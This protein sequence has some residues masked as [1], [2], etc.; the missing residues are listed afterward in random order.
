MRKQP[1]KNLLKM[2]KRPEQSPHQRK[3]IDGKW[4]YEKMLCV[5]VIRKYK[6]KQKMRYHSMPIRGLKYRTQTVPNA[7]IRIWSFRNSHSMLE[8]CKI[9][10]QHW[11]PALA[12]SYKQHSFHIIQK[13]H[14]LFLFT[15]MSLKDVHTKIC[16]HACCML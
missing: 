8:K 15:Q 16:T 1:D 7:V 3:F 6:L 11:K 4:P 12:V 14:L 2:V 10:R 13:L 5:I 9:I